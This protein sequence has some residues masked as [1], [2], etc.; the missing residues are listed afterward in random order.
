MWAKPGDLHLFEFCENGAK[1]TTWEITNRRAEP[2]FFSGH[3]VSAL[4]AWPDH[5]LEELGRLTHPMRWDPET[6]RYLP[7]SWHDAFAEIGRE[8]KAIPPNQAVFYASGRGSLET[9]YMYSL[10]ARLY[11]TN[12]LPDSSNMC[13][14]T[15]S[16]AL[17]ESIGVPVGT[18]TLDD[19]AKTDCIFFFGQNVGSN[20]P[21]M[22]HNLQDA[23]RRGVP[24]V[25]FNPLRER[26]LEEFINPQ[27]PGEMLNRT[28]TRISSQYHQ[29]KSG[30]DLAA[31]IGM[32][33]ALLA[34]DDEAQASGNPRVLDVDFIAEHTTG[35][36]EFAAA[37]RD[38]GW[39]EL[40][41]R[42][43]LSR[44]SRATT[45][46]PARSTT[47]TRSASSS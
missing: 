43:G 2:A 22:L 28:P 19:F 26:G 15:T 34:A 47:S 25:T 6:D 17:P 20:A 24:I 11:G 31:I 9:A 45:P 39:D 13:H 23:S 14:E 1:A 5:D 21:R 44:R 8:L 42:S 12:N 36:D 29:V 38:H 32:C 27:A 10:L 35:F 41:Q 16:V 46:G 4:E 30:G 40:E 37:V 33:K 7:V 3:R 18:V